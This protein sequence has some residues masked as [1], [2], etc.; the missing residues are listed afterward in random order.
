M[1]LKEKLVD[2]MKTAVVR[3]AAAWKKLWLGHSPD[4]PLPIPA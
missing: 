1:T 3:D 2:D 4:R